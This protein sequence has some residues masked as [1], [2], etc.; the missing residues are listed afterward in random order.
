MRDDALTG[1]EAISNGVPAFQKPKSRNAATTLT[2]LG[3]LAVTLFMGTIDARV[4]SGR[5]GHEHPSR[6]WV[7]RVAPFGGGERW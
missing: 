3:A 7:C 2:L 5:R 4:V 6:R 1:V